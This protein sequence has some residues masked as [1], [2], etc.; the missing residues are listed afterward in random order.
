M[1]LY[2]S[3]ATTQPVKNTS[4]VSKSLLFECRNSGRPSS[5]SHIPI[6][7]RFPTMRSSPPVSSSA[8]CCSFTWIRSTAGG[9]CPN[10]GDSYDSLGARPTLRATIDFSSSAK[11]CNICSS[12]LSWSRILL[13]SCVPPSK[14][15]P[16]PASLSK[17]D[18]TTSE[19][20][21]SSLSSCPS[22]PS[23]CS[24]SSS[25]SLLSSSGCSRAGTTSS[26]AASENDT[27]AEARAFL[28]EAL[29]DVAMSS[30]LPCC[31]LSCP[32]GG[33]GTSACSTPVVPLG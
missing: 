32:A 21:A 17:L 20:A 2:S 7:A 4:S 31:P 23:S 11:S 27:T 18:A 16:P 22:F 13:T 3:S 15:P 25:S 1:Y 33:A 12:A 24:S 8:A 10:G 28:L 5:G 29:R 19:S 30:W 6:S 26:K 9:P 14:P